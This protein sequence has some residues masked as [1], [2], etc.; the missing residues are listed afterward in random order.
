[1]SHFE[2]LIN[3]IPLLENLEFAMK[4]AQTCEKKNHKNQQ[5][6]VKKTKTYEKKSHKVTN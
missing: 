6:S 5:T 4:K 1:M 3:K 2:N